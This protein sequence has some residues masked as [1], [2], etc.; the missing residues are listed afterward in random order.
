MP[1][2]ARNRFTPPAER[3][4]EALER[5]PGARTRPLN[6]LPK[7]RASRLIVCALQPPAPILD[8]IKDLPPLRD[9]LAPV[10][11]C[12]QRVARELI[13]QL[14]PAVAKLFELFGFMWVAVF[15]SRSP[16]AI[17][18]PHRL[19][20]H[21]VRYTVSMV[22]QMEQSNVATMARGGRATIVPLS[23]Q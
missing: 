12:D 16:H 2:G 3:P 18:G 11:P 20:D 14:Q 19:L 15:L 23:P 8:P 22:Q 7:R 4:P 5:S 13:G 6:A 10:G 17:E 1:H 9:T 21:E